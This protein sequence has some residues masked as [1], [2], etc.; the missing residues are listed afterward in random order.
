MSICERLPDLLRLTILYDEDGFAT[1]VFSRLSNL[2][3][4]VIGE[5]CAIRVFP[6]SRYTTIAGDKHPVIGR[7]HDTHEEGPQ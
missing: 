1:C 5:K 4:R 2:V 7:A 3:I 6:A